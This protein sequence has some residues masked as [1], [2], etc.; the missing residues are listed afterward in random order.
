MSK[1]KTTS[2]NGY[3]MTFAN[4]YTVSVQWNCGNYCSDRGGDDYSG[5]NPRECSSVEVAAWDASGEWV[6]LSE[7]DD[8]IGWQTADD[9]AA[10]M[11]KV[12]AL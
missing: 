3:H 12:A 4:G 8:V 9:V 2:R 7:S 5:K 1:F 6:K 10:I 11:A